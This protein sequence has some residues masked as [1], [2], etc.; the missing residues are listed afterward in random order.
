VGNG[1]VKSANGTLVLKG[2][3]SDG[4]TMSGN[5]MEITSR[6]EFVFKI[7]KLLILELSC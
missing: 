5:S 3:E 6:M 7:L 2:S 1:V 4:S